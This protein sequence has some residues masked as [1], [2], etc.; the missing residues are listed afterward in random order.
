[1]SNVEE[2]ERQLDAVVSEALR[3]AERRLDL[4]SASKAERADVMATTRAQLRR[5][6]D[7]ATASALRSAV[8]TSAGR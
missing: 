7:A 6:R 2:M 1:M 8:A 3:R 5:W 4:A